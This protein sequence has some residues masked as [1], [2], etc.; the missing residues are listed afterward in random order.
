MK[1]IRL[2]LLLPLLILFACED[3]EKEWYNMQFVFLEQ[4]NH[5]NSLLLEGECDHLCVD[6]PTYSY[7]ESSRELHDFIGQ[8][9]MDKNIVLLLGTGGS[10]S[11]DA[12]SGAGTGLTAVSDFPFEGN[13]F[14]INKITPEGTVFFT[15]RD[16]AMVLQANEEWQIQNTW[17]EPYYSWQNGDTIGM[18]Q[19]THSDRITNWGILDKENFIEPMERE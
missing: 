14:K 18:V 7:N 3:E 17:I 6:F 10:L 9:K 13:R 2:L 4:H 15:Y 11:G 19:Y 8:I 12:G 1:N 16:S 5:T